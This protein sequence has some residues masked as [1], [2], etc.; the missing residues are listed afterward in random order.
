M[1]ASRKGLILPARLCFTLLGGVGVIAMG[2]CQSSAPATNLPPYDGGTCA[3]KAP[4]G[5]ICAPA[6]YQEGDPTP[7]TC[8]Y[9]CDLPEGPGASNSQCYTADGSAVLDCA[10]DV[11]ADGGAIVLC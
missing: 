9:F 11:S 5:Q 2:G 6:C 3:T 4:P 7:Y 8:D 10:R 1:L